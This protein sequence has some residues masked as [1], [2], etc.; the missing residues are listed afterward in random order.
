MQSG[1]A[2][3]F[4]AEPDFTP[5]SC[6]HCS[7]V[8]AVELTV[9]SDYL[10]LDPFISVAYATSSSKMVVRMNLISAVQPLMVKQARKRILGGGVVAMYGVR[11]MFC[12]QWVD[13]VVQACN[14]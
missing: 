11:G 2:Y 1:I 12:N 4:L 8:E 7:W 3:C 6:L 14:G 13:S 9:A 5:G 10:A